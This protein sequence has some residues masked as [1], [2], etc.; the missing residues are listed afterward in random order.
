MDL[1]GWRIEWWAGWVGGL[2]GG[3]GKL[4]GLG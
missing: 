3:L 1:V 4:S 2:S